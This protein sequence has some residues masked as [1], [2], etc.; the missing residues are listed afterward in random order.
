[1]LQQDRA[2]TGMVDMMEASAAYRAN[3]AV[4]RTADKLAQATLQIL[5]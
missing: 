4:L 1:M 2:V 5:G 3:L